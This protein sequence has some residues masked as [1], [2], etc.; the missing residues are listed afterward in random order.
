MLARNF[1][2][3]LLTLSRRHDAVCQTERSS[4]VP[5]PKGFP[6]CRNKQFWLALI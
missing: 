4:P 2:F 6:R 5:S 1:H 3:Q